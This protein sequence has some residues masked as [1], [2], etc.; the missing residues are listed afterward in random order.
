MLPGSRPQAHM[1]SVLP[2]V[3]AFVTCLVLNCSLAKSLKKEVPFLL[4]PWYHHNSVNG[5]RI[6]LKL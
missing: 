2:L 1:A 4:C 6:K 3:T 5:H